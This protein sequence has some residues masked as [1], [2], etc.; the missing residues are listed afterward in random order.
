MKLLEFNCII[1][2]LD[3]GIAGGSGERGTIGGC[4]P[5]V[6]SRAQISGVDLA[7]AFVIFAFL[8]TAF[9]LSKE[10]LLVQAGVQDSRM[11]VDLNRI[12]YWLLESKGTPKGWY[13]SNVV[14]PG[15]IYSPGVITQDKLYELLIMNY[16]KVTQVIGVEGYYFR[17]ELV[18]L[19]GFLLNVSYLN[20]SKEAA[21]GFIAANA[22]R[23]RRA[24]RTVAVYAGD[25]V[26]VP[27][28]LELTL[29]K[30]ASSGNPT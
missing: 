5:P 2:W 20:Y 13:D 16:S 1:N 6:V 28:R 11:E 15:L 9:V 21:M 18:D 10:A 19:D 29:S 24:S 27:A 3:K 17:L 7:L 12:E 23:S 8:A 14:I 22:T 25:F 26:Y 30:N 4:N